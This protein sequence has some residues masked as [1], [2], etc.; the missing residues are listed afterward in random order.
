MAVARDDLRRDR[1][2]FEAELLRNIFLDP[3][4]NISEGPDGAGDRAGRDFF[5]RR[6]EPGAGSGELGVMPGELQ[7]KGGRLGVDAV[8]APHRRRQFVLEG[9][10][11]QHREQCLEIGE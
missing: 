3:R 1:L 7:S 4:I 10:P 2:G 6:D 8:A 9:A 5:A 11:L